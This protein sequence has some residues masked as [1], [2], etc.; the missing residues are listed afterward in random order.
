MR[1]QHAADQLEHLVGDV[2]RPVGE[3]DGRARASAVAAVAAARDHPSARPGRRARGCPAAGSTLLHRMALVAADVE[4]LPRVAGERRAGQPAPAGVARAPACGVQ[5]LRPSSRGGRLVLPVTI[6]R[7]S[8]AAPASARCAR[9][10]R[11]PDDRRWRRAGRGNRS[12]RS[13]SRSASSTTSCLRLQRASS[14]LRGVG[15]EI[16]VLALEPG[17]RQAPGIG[18]RVGLAARGGLG[19]VGVAAALAEQHDDVMAILVGHGGNCARVVP[20]DANGNGRGQARPFLPW[21][22][23]RRATLPA[24]DYCMNQPWLTTMDWPRERRA[25]G[26]GE[27]ENGVGHLVGGGE[28]RR[29]PCPSA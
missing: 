2:D 21:D 29:P 1:L 23:G 10:C 15:R 8:A 22:R 12:S 19:G 5:D 25:R 7:R 26:A 17:A 14:R 9:W 4:R 18:E 27:V 28:L 13:S 3:H 24:C 16:G 11:L 20:A 6:R